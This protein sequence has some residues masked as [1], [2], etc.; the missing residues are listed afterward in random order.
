MPR[1][2]YRWTFTAGAFVL[3]AQTALAADI[4]ARQAATMAQQGM[5]NSAAF[6]SGF[7][8][9][10]GAENLAASGR[11][12][13]SANNLTIV[14]GVMGGAAFAGAGATATASASSSSSYFSRQEGIGGIGAGATAIGNNLNVNVIGNWNTVIIDSTQINNGDQN[15]TVSLNGQLKL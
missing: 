7:G 9:G 3:V 13:D 15:A 6:N 14:N 12:R 4:A 8:M 10:S 1:F 5:N 11:V 2:C